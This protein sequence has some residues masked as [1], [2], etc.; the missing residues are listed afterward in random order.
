MNSS[1]YK[2]FPLKGEQIHCI[3]CQYKYHKD[4]PLSTLQKHLRVKHRFSIRRP[5]ST[6]QLGVAIIEAKAPIF[7]SYLG[8]EPFNQVK[9]FSLINLLNPNCGEKESTEVV[10][11]KWIIK[12]KIPLSLVTTD[13]FF[14]MLRQLSPNIV[15]PTPYRL[16]QLVSKE[17]TSI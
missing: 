10:I 5:L 14:S 4:A 8:P 17:T 13:S 16:R 12:E 7:S 2:Y 15:L 1:I 3:V 11:S 9:G 6:T